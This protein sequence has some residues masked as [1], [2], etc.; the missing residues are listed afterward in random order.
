[1]AKGLSEETLNKIKTNNLVN[2]LLFEKWQIRRLVGE[3][4]VKGGDIFQSS[5]YLFVNGHGNQFQFGVAGNDIVASG[6]G[7]PLMKAF[8]PKPGPDP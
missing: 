1:M 7:G 5:N 3:G 4:N 8:L 6:V 2:R